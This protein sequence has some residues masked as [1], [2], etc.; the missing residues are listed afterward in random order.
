MLTEFHWFCSSWYIFGGMLPLNSLDLNWRPI[1][2]IPCNSLY[3]LKIR[4]LLNQLA[5]SLCSSAMVEVWPQRCKLLCIQFAFYIYH[6]T[7]ERKIGLEKE[8]V[9]VFNMG[10]V[11]IYMVANGVIRRRFNDTWVDQNM[12]LVLI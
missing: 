3:F 5:S 6:T 1:A 9:V 12:G 8:L 4:L 7:S 2:I 10:N 11:L